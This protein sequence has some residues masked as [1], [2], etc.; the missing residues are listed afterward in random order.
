MSTKQEEK[1]GKQTRE[2]RAEIERL[3]EEP[4]AKFGENPKMWQKPHD[5]VIH[6]VVADRE[7][8]RK[9]KLFLKRSGL[10]VLNEKPIRV[11]HDQSRLFKFFEKET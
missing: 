1:G 5:W 6:V 8:L 4:R 2:E 9:L 3:K 7:E 10:I 11:Y